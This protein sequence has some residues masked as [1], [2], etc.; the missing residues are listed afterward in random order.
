M[1]RT[2]EDIEVHSVSSRLVMWQLSSKS[3]GLTESVRASRLWKCW[4]LSSLPKDICCALEKVGWNNVKKLASFEGS[5]VQIVICRGILIYTYDN[6]CV[7][8][9]FDCKHGKLSLKLPY[10]FLLAVR[11]TNIK[12]EIYLTAVIE[13]KIENLSSDFHFTCIILSTPSEIIGFG[14][15]CNICAS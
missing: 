11:S 9:V 3:A 7:T 15:K 8:M 14:L 6:Q 5:L 4:D 10:K 13:F 12:V 2:S 1:L